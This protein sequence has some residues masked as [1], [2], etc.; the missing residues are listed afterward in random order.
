MER[1]DEAAVREQIAYYRARAPEYD[2]EYVA[3]DDMRALRPVL[4]ELPVVGDV[5]ELACGTGQ[6]TGPL[7]ARARSLTAVDA[8]PETLAIAR[9][10]VAPAPVEFVCADLFSWR[11]ARRYDTVF[12]GFWL[13]HVPPGRLPG[14]WQMVADALAPGGKAV[15]MDNGPG[16]AA[17]EEVLP[18]GS[19]PAVRRRLEDGSEHR[20]VKVF[21]DAEQL[22]RDLAGWGWTGQVRPVGTN[23]IVGTAQP[24]P[25]A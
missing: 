14:F 5:L 4:D 11:P 22:V 25:G 12:F 19:V 17:S 15:F 9:E 21:H 13:S 16:E 1:D 7:A 20:V 6:W 23:F 2:Q 10:R 3:R 8:A 18:D 24:R